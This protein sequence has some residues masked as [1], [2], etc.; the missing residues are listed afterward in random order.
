LQNLEIRDSVYE[1]Q[2]CKLNR[3]RGKKNKKLT[4]QKPSKPATPPKNGNFIP[5]TIQSNDQNSQITTFQVS[6]PQIE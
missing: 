5:K 3:E 2:R 1:N 4:S 6:N